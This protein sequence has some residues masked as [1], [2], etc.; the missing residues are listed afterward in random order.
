MSCPGTKVKKTALSF[1]LSP[2]STFHYHNVKRKSRK[3]QP[4]VAISIELCNHDSPPPSLC[5][6]LSV[7]LLIPAL[8]AVLPPWV[9]VSYF[10]QSSA[11]V[12]TPP[13]SLSLSYPS[14][15]KVHLCRNVH[16]STSSCISS[17]CATSMLGRFVGRKYKGIENRSRAYTRTQVVFTY[18]RAFIS[19]FY[20]CTC[21][22]LWSIADKKTKE[23]EK[24]AWC[25]KWKLSGK[26]QRHKGR[27]DTRKC[28]NEMLCCTKAGRERE[29]EKEAR[30]TRGW[31][32]KILWERVRE[33]SK[34]DR[35]TPCMHV[36]TSAPI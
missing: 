11:L 2:L 3:I 4:M 1:S 19:P 8:V 10:L 29:T 9:L 12:L 25:G 13:P 36:C 22:H 7:S 35:H 5:L 33:E 23:R 15:H 27:K 26:R 17:R 6:P 18:F 20:S 28:L 31:S 34:E 21:S 32:T 16:S 30:G 14:S 24:S